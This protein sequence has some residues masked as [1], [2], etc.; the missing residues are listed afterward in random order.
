VEDAC[1]GLPEGA[2]DRLF[3]PYVQVGEDR[4]G[5]GL[6]L[7]IVLRSVKAHEGDVRVR[8]LPGK[9]CI[10]TIELPQSRADSRAAPRIVETC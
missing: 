5:L 9:G 4:S 7:P 3:D 10:F 8:N 2:A 6:G 1:G